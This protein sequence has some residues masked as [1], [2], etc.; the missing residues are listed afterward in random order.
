MLQEPPCASLFVLCLMENL[1]SDALQWEQILSSPQASGYF[2]MNWTGGTIYRQSRTRL[3]KP[4][5]SRQRQQ[6]FLKARARAA[7]QKDSTD[8]EYQPGTFCRSS[9]SLSRQSRASNK[10]GHSAGQH[11]AQAT[12]RPSSEQARKRPRVLASNPGDFPLPTPAQFMEHYNARERGELPPLS[13]RGQ[14][15][16]NRNVKKALAKEDPW[17]F[18]LKR[19]ASPTPPKKSRARR[20]SGQ[21][22]S[23]AKTGLPPHIIRDEKNILRCKLDPRTDGIRREDV[24]VR[25]GSQEKRPLVSSSAGRSHAASSVRMPPDNERHHAS[26][27]TSSKLQEHRRHYSGDKKGSKVEDNGRHRPADKPSSKKNPGRSRHFTAPREEKRLHE[28]HTFPAAQVYEESLG[29]EWSQTTRPTTSPT[30]PL[31]TRISFPQLHAPIP[32]RRVVSQSLHSFKSF[33]SENT[34]SV[35]AQAGRVVPPVPASQKGKNDRWRTWR[36]ESSSPIDNDEAVEGS[37]QSVEGSVPSPGVSL[38]SRPVPEPDSEPRLPNLSH[39]TRTVRS[40]HGFDKSQNLPQ[41]L[42]SSDSSEILSRYEEMVA[43]LRHLQEQSKP[44]E[45]SGPYPGSDSPDQSE[46]RESDE[47]HFLE[48]LPSPNDSMDFRDKKD[49]T[50]FRPSILPKLTGQ[51]DADLYENDNPEQAW[52]L[53]VLGDDRTDDVEEAAYNEAKRDV[54]RSL[55]PSDCSTC[56]GNNTSVSRNSWHRVHQ[57]GW[58]I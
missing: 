16:Y 12:A 18:R 33:D 43:R 46:S 1:S 21:V 56:V 48:H 37:W 40:K 45:Q 24:V 15:E 35:L 39:L 14:K 26:G 29:N 23:Q 22:E 32:T 31:V 19:P 49:N 8:R 6:E 57:S 27:K 50:S 34:N 9:S 4:D 58:V 53:F 44:Y 51:T 28:H 11:A 30:Q 36:R 38:R 42:T 41:V 10:S 25:V 20:P 7:K 13:E 3:R 52:K 5:P 55:Q 54:A 17:G 47:P 2:A